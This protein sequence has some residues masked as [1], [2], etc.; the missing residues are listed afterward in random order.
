MIERKRGVVEQTCIG[1]DFLMKKNKIDVHNG[2][3]SFKDKEYDSSHSR[4][5]DSVELK[6]K[7]TIIATGS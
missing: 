6:T 2:F 7:N 3:G 5:G 1:I 4:K